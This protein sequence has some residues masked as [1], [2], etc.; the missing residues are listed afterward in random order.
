MHGLALDH[1]AW[2]SPWRARSVRDKGVL[3][4]GLLLAALT[5]PPFP[6]GAGAG[7][8]CLALLI[9][10]VR[11]GG[12]RLLRILWFPALS[13]LI[14]VA[15]VAVSVTWSG[16]PRVQV[17]PGGGDVAVRIAVRA[18]AAT[19]AM[20]VL[21]CSTPLADLLASLRRAHVPDPLIEVASLTY[22]FSVGLIECA[23]AIHAAQRARLG[24]ATRTAGMRSAS[25]A[26]SSLFLRAWERAA[27][28]ED[29]L[30]GRGH[31]GS[32]RTLDPPRRRSRG[33]LLA[34][35]AL[36]MLPVAASLAWEVGR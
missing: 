31:D 9:G 36:V 6:G 17:T 35:I 32:L 7:A 5:L 22:R 11:V 20:L 13:I 8:I 14:G 29:G 25:L 28:L 23:A 24:Y 26:A 16:G 10:P 27:R 4:G 18:L 3:A 15:T 2:S 19:L 1:A 34:G 33:F 12:L 30:A 21:A